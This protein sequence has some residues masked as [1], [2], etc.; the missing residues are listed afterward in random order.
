MG[1]PQGPGA[2]A[3]AC[4]A[5]FRTLQV[6]PETVGPESCLG[7]NMLAASLQCVFCLRISGSCD[8]PASCGLRSY[9]ICVIRWSRNRCVFGCTAADIWGSESRIQHWDGCVCPSLG[10][11]TIAP[12]AAGLVSRD[13]TGKRRGNLAGARKPRPF[14]RGMP[15]V[16]KGFTSRSAWACMAIG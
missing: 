2:G 11:D 7:T 5:F 8:P 14:Y 1:V 4:C 10:D 12:T 15:C 3:A 6:L 16:Q 9:S 13:P